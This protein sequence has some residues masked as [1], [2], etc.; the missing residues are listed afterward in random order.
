VPAVTIAAIQAF[1]PPTGYKREGA[2]EDSYLFSCGNYYTPTGVAKTS[3]QFKALFKCQLGSCRSNSKAKPIS[4]IRG[5]KSNVNK[6]VKQVHKLQG[7]V[8]A[9]RREHI[10]KRQGSVAAAMDA[11]KTFRVGHKR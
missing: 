8:G 4:C 2:R 7:S 11:S 6:H 1:V 5:N 3:A 10:D 9:A